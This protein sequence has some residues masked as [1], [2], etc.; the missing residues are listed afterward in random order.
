M[1]LANEAD[2]D[3]T[4]VAVDDAGAENLFAEKTSFGM[5]PQRPVPHVR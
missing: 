4:T 1:L 5:V 3:L 2:R